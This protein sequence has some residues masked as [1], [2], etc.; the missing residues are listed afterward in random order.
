MRRLCRFF[1]ILILACTVA[2]CS[3]PEDS[4][5][6]LMWTVLSRQEYAV[7]YKFVPKD[8]LAVW[9]SYQGKSKKVSLDAEVKISLA[10][11]PLLSMDELEKIPSDGYS[12]KVLGTNLIIVEYLGFS[13]ISPMVVVEPPPEVTP[14]VDPEEPEEPDDGTK[15][16]PINII[17]AK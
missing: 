6:D 10:E 11:H 9:T 7:G 1:T 13:A 14:P 5:I 17:W 8:D 3:E 4:G 2:A 16:G 12:L 15:T